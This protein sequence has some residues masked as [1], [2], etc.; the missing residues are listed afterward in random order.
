VPVLVGAISLQAKDM[1]AL[2]MHRA[3]HEIAAG[4]QEPK[5]DRLKVL[6]NEM[7]DG[8][9]PCSSF[10]GKSVGE[11]ARKT[12]CCDLPSSVVRPLA[13]LIAVGATRAPVMLLTLLQQR[14]SP[15][16]KRLFFKK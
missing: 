13:A 14:A 2:C 9:S 16:D 6:G 11:H 10:K 15:S 3:N 8:K 5:D 1:T 4:P 7:Q 12:S